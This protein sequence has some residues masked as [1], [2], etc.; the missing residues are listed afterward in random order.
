MCR[1]SSSTQKNT[2]LRCFRIQIHNRSRTSR[3]SIHWCNNWSTRQSCI[4]CSPRTNCHPRT[5]PGDRPGKQCMARL[6]RTEPRHCCRPCRSCTRRTPRRSPSNTSRPPRR[7]PSVSRKRLYRSQCS[8]FLPRQSACSARKRRCSLP[9]SRCNPRTRQRTRSCPTPRVLPKTSSCWNARRCS[10]RPT[11]SPAS[12]RTKQT[13]S[14]P[15]N[16][17]NDR[18]CVRSG[19]RPRSSAPPLRVRGPKRP[20]SCSRRMAAMACCLLQC[21]LSVCCAFRRKQLPLKRR[22]AFYVRRRCPRD[23][24]ALGSS[25]GSPWPPFPCSSPAHGVPQACQRRL[26]RGR[27]GHR[28]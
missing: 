25:Q 7:Y 20:G 5:L 11:Y 4:A 27:H 2:G 8:G 14:T 26:G 10:R 23:P 17:P 22:P 13:P 1:N 16:R 3:A 6:L 9:R 28:G 18:G 21:R 19:T 15:R 24:G 12:P